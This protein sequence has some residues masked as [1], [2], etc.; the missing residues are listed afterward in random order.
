MFFRTTN[1]GEKVFMVINKSILFIFLIVLFSHP[2]GMS[3]LIVDGKPVIEMPTPNAFPVPDEIVDQT[4]EKLHHALDRYRFNGTALVAVKGKVI[5]EEARGYANLN[6]KTPLNIESSFQLASASKPFTALS[7]MLLKERHLLNYDDTVSMYLADFPYPDVTIRNLLNHT[8][9]LQNYM[10]LVD[11]FWKNDSTISNQKMLELVVAHNLP[12]NNRPGRR[13]EYSNTGYA[14]LALVVEKITNQY[15]GDFLQKEIF[16]KLGMTHSFVYDRNKIEQD[17]NQVLGYASQSR[18]ARQY[19]HDPNNEIL[20]DKSIYSSVNDI[21]KFTKALNNYE[22]VDK[23]T[24]DEAY[25]KAIL[26]NKHT[27]NYGF[28]WRF[29]DLD[30]K[31]YIFHN[32]AWHGFTSTITLNPDEDI[33]VILLNNTNASIATIKND[34]LQILDTQFEPYIN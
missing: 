31:E 28:G 30:D 27:V 2:L 3:A 23:E 5:F 26:K 25:T 16:D 19:F 10:Y 21:Y 20:G 4:Q 34:L 13:F 29:K 8:S 33:T 1:F 14:I 7:I 22:L 9:G 24:L 17:S 11:H 12:L 6:T 18:R 15:F 32:G